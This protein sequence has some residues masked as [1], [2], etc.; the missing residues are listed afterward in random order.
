MMKPET[1]DS[2][3]C[4]QQ[5]LQGLPPGQIEGR[6]EPVPMELRPMTLNVPFG[7]RT[8]AP[9]DPMSPK[10]PERTA[11]KTCDSVTRLARIALSEITPSETRTTGRAVTA[12]RKKGNL[13]ES[14]A[15]RNCNAANNSSAVAPS[16]N[17][18]S[19]LKRIVASVDP[20]ATVTTKSNAFI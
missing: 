12:R 14:H 19:L 5:K 10:P 2:A 7:S 9:T 20:K 16:I 18:T 8:T 1:F 15:T 6:A 13:V 4:F 3:M 17:A 11:C